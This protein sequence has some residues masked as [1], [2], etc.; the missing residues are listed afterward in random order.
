MTKPDERD[1]FLS[2]KRLID[3]SKDRLAATINASLTTLYWQ[4]GK[5]ISSE[6]LGTKRADYGKQTIIL[7]AQRLVLEYGNSFSEKNLRRMVQFAEAF[8]DSSIVVSLIRQLSWT[9]IL[10]I[11]PMTD[12]IK[13]DF[14]IQMCVHERWSVR[15]LRERVNSMLFERT[16]ISHKP[17]EAIISDLAL[18]G[19]ESRVNPD[20]VFRDPYILDFL[21]LSG[22]Y[23]ERDLE[24][25]II[26]ELQKFM[27]EMGTDF[28][29]LARQK[30]ISSDN[31][32]YYIDL[33]FYHRRMKCLIVVDLKIGEFEA[34]YKGQMELYLRYLEKYEVIEGEN[35]PIGLILC[36][37][38][39]EEHIELLQLE[40]SN[41][42][43]ADYL[44]STPSQKLLQQKLQKA[45]EVA[46]RKLALEA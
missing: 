24:N 25:A 32:D 22:N 3:D 30:R 21:G 14:Y 11:L 19:A 18:L 33:L 28:A 46:R 43:V 1:L 9:H 16:K 37:G 2:V 20:L 29:F 23:S 40:K 38:K 31:L 13:R 44:L 7:L 27:C 15:T 5:K 45:I 4:V 36:T 41:I 6:I 8:P 42:R 10:V 34:G 35:P 39:K 12:T 26:A 17:A